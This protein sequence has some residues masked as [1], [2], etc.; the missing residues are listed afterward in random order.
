MIFQDDIC[1]VSE[2]PESANDADRRIDSMVESKLLSPNSLE[3]K[4]LSRKYAK[5]AHSPGV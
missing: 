5:H 4:R 3:R 2:D 1:K